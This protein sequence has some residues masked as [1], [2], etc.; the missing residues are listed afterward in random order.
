MQAI[1]CV[2]SLKVLTRSLH[3]GATQDDVHGLSEQELQ[4]LKG[5]VTLYVDV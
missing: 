5:L 3:Q 1:C 2:I 4:I